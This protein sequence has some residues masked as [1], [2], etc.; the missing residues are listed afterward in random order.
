MP[1]CARGVL[2]GCMAKACPLRDRLIF[3]LSARLGL[4]AKEIA[5]LQWEVVTAA[6]GV[7]ADVIAFPNEAANSGHELDRKAFYSQQHLRDVQNSSVHSA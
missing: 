5:A 6:E 7:L 4:K 2:N 3:L 1:L